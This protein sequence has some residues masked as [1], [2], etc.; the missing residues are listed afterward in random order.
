MGSTAS[1]AIALVMALSALTASCSKVKEYQSRLEAES[2]SEKWIEDGGEFFFDL[3]PVRRFPIYVPL[4]GWESLTREG[5]HLAN[6]EGNNKRL[7]K[8]FLERDYGKEWE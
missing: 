4:E 3:K 7:K 2:A 5:K 6:C 8:E 1:K